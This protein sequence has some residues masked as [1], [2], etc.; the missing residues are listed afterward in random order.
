MV[1]YASITAALAGL[2]SSLSVVLGSTTAALN[3]TSATGLVS[4]AARTYHLSGAQARSVYGRAPYGKPA[5]RSLY[6]VGWMGADSNIAA[7]KAALLLGPSPSDAAAQALRGN[8]K[9]LSRLRAS[10]VTVSQAAAAIGR[11]Y[12]DGC[13]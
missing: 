2:V 13:N 1:E 8:P 5:L 6:A 9:L 7:C 3:A 4:A 11:G 10:G 12:T